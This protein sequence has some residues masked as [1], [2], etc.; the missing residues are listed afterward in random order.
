MGAAQGCLQV[1]VDCG[2]VV[3]LPPM[4]TTAGVRHASR[5]AVVHRRAHWCARDDVADLWWL[6]ADV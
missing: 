3:L 1:A 5:A 2:L 6:Q 4:R